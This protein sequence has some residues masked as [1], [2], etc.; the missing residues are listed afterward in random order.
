MVDD[1]GD[2]VFGPGDRLLFYAQGLPTRFWDSTQFYLFKNPYTDT[3]VYWVAVGF[4]GE[5]LEPERVDASPRGNP[6]L[7]WHE[8]FAHHERDLFVPGKK[9]LVW[10]GETMELPSSANE[11]RYEFRLNLKDVAEGEGWVEVSVAGAETYGRA[12]VDLYLNGLDNYLGRFTTS[13]SYRTVSRF[14]A[15]GFKEGDNT[16]IINLVRSDTMRHE[17]YLDYID[18][19]YPRRNRFSGELHLRWS[20]LQGWFDITLEGSRPVFAWD[21][22]DPE[23]PKLLKNFSWS[24][25][26][27]VLSD[28]VFPGKH[29]YLTTFTR[30]PPY[31][32]VLS[33]ARNLR[34]TS[35]GADL[36]KIPQGPGPYLMDL[37]GILNSATRVSPLRRAAPSQT[38]SQLM[39]QSP[40]LIR[41]SSWS[42]AAERAK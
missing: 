22:T 33:M 29:I 13:P 41:A 34:D 5:P 4:E 23:K 19:S 40:P 18:L 42:P 27:T 9:G 17:V 39:S 31:L 1:G 3:V 2:G 8:G 32:R 7:D 38:P 10:V 24:S 20:Q 14:E 30:K 16:L 35:L 15:Q 37:N 11:A 6:P 26:K 25:G 12:T 21:V 28:S 36:K